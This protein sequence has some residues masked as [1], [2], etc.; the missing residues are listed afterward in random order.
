M[1]TN[2]YHVSLFN[3]TE[4]V[5]FNEELLETRHCFCDAQMCP[6]NFSHSTLCRKFYQH[7]TQRRRRC[8]SYSK[9]N[10]LPVSRLVNL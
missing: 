7:S 6:S 9:G 8:H 4:T 5:F 3:A 10:N 1:Y 2:E